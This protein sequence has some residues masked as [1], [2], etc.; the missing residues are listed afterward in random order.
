MTPRTFEPDS[1]ALEGHRREILVHCYR[2]TG[3]FADAEDLAQ[4]T[5]LR[6]WRNRD[7]FDGRA[8]MR[9]WLYR[10]ATNACLD[11]LKRHERRSLPT[12]SITEA[13]ERDAGI[14]P[15]PDRTHA[16]SSRAGDPADT[17]V[18]AETT[19]LLLLAALRPLPPRQ[20]AAFIARA[21]LD[22]S[23][24]ETAILLDCSTTSVNSLVGRA[25]RAML[26]HASL[27]PSPSAAVEDEAIVSQYV[28][29]HHRADVD[30][31]VQLVA[32]DI[33][34]AMPPEPPCHGV[35]EARSFFT[36][37]LGPQRPGDWKLVPTRA[38]GAPAT[39]NYL[40]RPD[41]A[42]FRATSVDVLQ[43]RDGRIEMISCFLGHGMFPAF[44]LPVTQGD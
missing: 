26:T 35:D 6:A 11:F 8:S 19:S 5:F 22:F 36:H 4:E 30:A 40:R 31:L 37:I 32:A 14:Q 21:L 28:A 23:A 29:A 34:I 15:F 13:L 3:S 1:S 44:G 24:E 27:Q 39:A 12:G 7:E 17:V 2:M 33:R 9:T 41:D 16:P 10:I 38:N 25:R 20:R 42:V 43:V 18:Q